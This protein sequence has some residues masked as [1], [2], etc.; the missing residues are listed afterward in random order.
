MNAELEITPE[1]VDT[2][3][4]EISNSDSEEE[5]Q[6][7]DLCEC[8][9]IYELDFRELEQIP[10]ITEK[11][12]EGQVLEEIMLEGDTDFQEKDNCKNIELPNKQEI[13]REMVVWPNMSVET[14]C[15]QKE[16]VEMKTYNVSLPKLF[17]AKESIHTNEIE[18]EI[19][20][21]N[22]VKV[23]ELPRE[24]KLEIP[25]EQDKSHL[26][27]KLKKVLGHKVIRRANTTKL[28][29]REVCRPPP[30]PPYIL[31]INREVIGI[32]ENVVPKTRHPL[33]PPRIHGSVDREGMDIE[34]ECL[35]NTV[36]N[37]RP[38]PKPPPKGLGYSQTS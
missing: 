18:L 23:R 15:E 5:I 7:L 9:I 20:K 27:T 14:S 22:E 6:N 3:I 36:L 11:L 12:T 28:V 29:K 34:K 32:I 16:C 13:D 31:N 2:E 30:K 4:I 19:S 26:H 25:I 24:V 38:P 35:L 21:I 1:A 10:H 17:K 8:E 33:K 37:H